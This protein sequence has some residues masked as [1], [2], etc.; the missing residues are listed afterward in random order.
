VLCERR[1]DGLV[2]GHTGNFAECRF[3][4]SGRFEKGRIAAVRLTD[5]DRKEGLLLGAEETGR[6]E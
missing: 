4:S 6:T 5:I 1:R 3:A 2:E